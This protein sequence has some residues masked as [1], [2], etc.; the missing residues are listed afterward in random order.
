MCH[1]WFFLMRSREHGEITLYIYICIIVQ[2]YGIINHSQVHEM[3]QVSQVSHPNDQLC[4]L[5]NDPRSSGKLM[6][7]GW[8][9]TLWYT[10]TSDYGSQHLLFNQKNCFIIPCPAPR[11]PCLTLQPLPN[12]GNTKHIKPTPVPSPSKPS[13]DT[14]WDWPNWRD[15][16]SQ[17]GR[18]VAPKMENSAMAWWLRQPRQHVLKDPQWSPL[19]P[20]MTERTRVRCFGAEEV[21]STHTQKK[22]TYLKKNNIYIYI[23]VVVIRSTL[24]FIL[25]PLRP[26]NLHHR[27]PNF[28]HHHPSY[29][30]YFPQIHWQI[31]R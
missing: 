13:S 15:P 22:Y 28:H 11:I 23:Y 20:R 25:P 17:F 18:N 27:P 5:T 29:V 4:T 19:E 24:P 12:P 6:I 30:S 8:T 3:I 14:G 10:A 16:N 2:V 9:L 1:C 26:P 7:S 31:D 21:L